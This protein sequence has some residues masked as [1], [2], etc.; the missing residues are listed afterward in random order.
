VLPVL[1]LNGYKINNPTLLARISHEELAWLF[2][3]Y[4]CTPYFVEG[5]DPESMHQAL[6]ATLDHCVAEIRALQAQARST[7]EVF[8]P[9][10]PM[11]VLRL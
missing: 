5:S 10:W 4:G 9:R 7:G 2:Y 8:R 1:N 3:G 6:A 11:I